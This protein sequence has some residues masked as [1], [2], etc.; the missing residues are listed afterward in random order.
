[1]AR[2][3]GDKSIAR[4]DVWYIPEL[5][6]KPVHKFSMVNDQMTVDEEPPEV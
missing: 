2:I 3:E 1:M 5:G 4:T 6:A